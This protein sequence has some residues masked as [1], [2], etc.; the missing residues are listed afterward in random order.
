MTTEKLQTGV[1][2]AHGL[3]DWAGEYAPE[4]DPAQSQARGGNWRGLMPPVP[5]AGHPAQAGL[6]RRSKAQAVISD[7]QPVLKELGF[8]RITVL[9]TA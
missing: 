9:P 4:F 7:S 1:G 5:T 3:C 8:R 2:S 6:A